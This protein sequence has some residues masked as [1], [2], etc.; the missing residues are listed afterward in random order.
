MARYWVFGASKPLGIGLANDLKASHDVTCFSRSLPTS[1]TD[2]LSHVNV[3]FS[4]AKKTHEAIQTRMAADA[5]DGAV[6]CQRYRAPFGQSDVDAVKEGLDVELAPVLSVLDAFKAA[7][8]ASPFSLVLISSVAA[9]AAHNDIP[10]YYHVLKAVTVSAARTLAACGTRSG[11]RVN[12]IILGEFEKYPRG[13]YK[14][15]EKA[16][17]EALESF[18]LSRQL[19][20]ISDIAGVAE[21]LLSKNARYVTGQMIRLDGGMSGLAPEYVVRS[22]LAKD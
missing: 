19:C 9:F 12:C 21:F 16:K 4:D 7:R 5:P 8:R 14:A 17:F 6:F 18:T 22:M 2:R 13:D 20:T 1:E 10:L 15:Q 3:D 11:L